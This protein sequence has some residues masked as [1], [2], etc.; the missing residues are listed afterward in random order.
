MNPHITIDLRELEERLDEIVD[1]LG[2]IWE[3]LDEL[4]HRVE[5]MPYDAAWDGALQPSETHE[6]L[7]VELPAPERIPTPLKRQTKLAELVETGFIYR[8]GICG[9]LGRNARTCGSGPEH[10]GI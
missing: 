10:P 7:T 5:Q 9:L 2:V 6:D 8:C 1:R 3:R 4:N